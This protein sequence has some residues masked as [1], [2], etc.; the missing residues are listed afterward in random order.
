MNEG[1]TQLAEPAGTDSGS[2]ASGTQFGQYKIL[3]QLGAGGMGEVFRARDSRLGREVAIKILSSNPATKPD[4]VQRFEGEARSASALNHPNIVT[5][6][7]LGGVDSIQYIAMELVEGKTLRELLSAGL[8]PMHKVIHIAA[9]VADGLATAHEAGIVHR[10]LKPENIMVRHDGLVKILDFGLAKLYE[11]SNAAL[12]EI[13]TRAFCQTE[14]GIVIGTLG[15]MSPQQASGLPLDFRSDQFSFGLVVY[16]MATGRRALHR[17]TRVD[18]IAAIINEQPEPLGTLN[19]EA[20]APLCW[21]VEHCL[22]KDPEKRYAST[23]DLASELNTLLQHFAELKSERVDLPANKLPRQLTPFVGRDAE[24]SAVKEILLRDDVLLT[25]ITGPGGVGKTRLSLKVAEELMNRFP[26]GVHLVQLG[27][28]SDPDLVPSLIAQTLHL[29]AGGESPLETLKEHLRS[30]L[31]KPLLLLLDNFEHLVSVGPTVGE[32]LAIGSYLK[33]LVTSRAPLRIYGEHEFPMPPLTLPDSKSLPPVEFLPR[34]SA[35]ALFVQRAAAVRPDFVLTQENAADVVEICSRLDGLPLAIELAASRM[36]LLRPAALRARLASRLQLLTGG[37]RDLPERQQ[38]LR[39]AIDW[40]HDFLSAA[41][42]VLFRR[43]SVF[44][45]GCNLEEVEAVCNTR[46]DLE[47][48]LLDGI[49]SLVNHSLLQQIEQPEGEPRFAMLETIRE[50]ARE[51]L[52]ASGDEAQTRRAHAAYCLVLAEEGAAATTDSE[53]VKW[54][55]CFEVEHENLRAALEWLIE[56]GDA[57]WGLRLGLALFGFWEAREYL[58]EARDRLEKLIHLNSNAPAS[59]E[60]MRAVFAAGVLAAEQRDLNA[61]GELMQQSLEMA[62]E[63]NDKLSIAV[64]I[65]GLAIHARDRGDLA[66]ARTLFEESLGI[67]KDCDDRLAVARSL[68]NL[69]NVVR[70]QGDFA[71]ARSL[72]EES[73]E[74][75]REVGD[76]T[77]AAWSINYLGDVARDRGDSADARELYELS[78][79]AF[80]ELGDRWGIAGSLA[81]LGSLARDQHNFDRASSLYRESMRIFQELDHKRGIARL[82]D[83][84]ACLAGARL[85]P[86][87]AL[88]L[89]GAAAALREK[90]GIPLP[91]KEQATLETLL[92][93]ARRLFTNAEDTAIWLKG[94]A[95]PLDQAVDE[96]L[97]PTRVEAP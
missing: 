68:S 67:W 37:S 34:Y 33:I 50:Y 91:A 23:R 13:D 69:A 66:L 73:L 7:E 44:A 71:R 51:K 52:L 32:L 17:D 84:L 54:F 75:L 45:G 62:R 24:V 70:L 81:D 41:E 58:S 12:S 30:S 4:L 85:A 63:L 83:C 56:S 97:S 35:V 1:I 48:D 61:A 43:L 5:I 55:D 40:S 90:L 86:R 28:V 49:A 72:Y 78:L 14:V 11:Q 94:W 60:R 20:P 65:N 95:L 26:A 93:P 80:R 59:K 8:M 76:R 22:A 25:T 53:R 3:S 77:G 10:D 16:E 96:A 31:R 9:Q 92:E 15:Y 57:E 46:E 87:R 2:L 88:R 74:I 18:T 64:N 21:A 38:T 19:P 82:L 42:Q 29:R 6:Y 89:A 36:K 27:P 39:G 47:L 79:T